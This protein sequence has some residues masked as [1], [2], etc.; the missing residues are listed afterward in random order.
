MDQ[1]VVVDSSV[2][3][4]WL[5]KKNEKH[6]D[7][8]DR[9]MNDALEGKINLIS[10]E[11]AKYEIGNAL[12]KGKQLTPREALISL[13]TVY[14]LP[15]TFIS[16]SEDLAKETFSQAYK[17]TLTYYD[18]SFISL[19]KKLNAPL[20]TDNAKHQGVTKDIEVIV[21]KDY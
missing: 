12:L 18:A 19:A 10:P 16:E 3:M 15:I 13:R 4:K 6:I 17:N 2:I 9:L 14:A 20:I 21:L 1:K 8:A 5:N 11:L 7:R